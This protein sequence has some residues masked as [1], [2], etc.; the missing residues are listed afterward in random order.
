MDRVEAARFQWSEGERRMAAATEGKLGLEVVCDRLVAELRR[1][2]G[3]PFTAD[4][5][6][7]L[8]Y[9]DTDWCLM[10]AMATVPDDPR[11]WDASTVTDAAFAKYLRE[12][13]DYAGGRIVA[14]L[15][16]EADQAP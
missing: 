13:G 7:N 2:L 6:A 10:I 4:E 8:Y 3:G 1:R 16:G 5:L 9:E 11:A 12:A 14:P 15:E